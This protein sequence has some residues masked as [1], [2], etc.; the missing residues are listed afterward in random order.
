MLKVLTIIGARPQIIKAAAVSRA[1]RKNF[2]DRVKEI[3]VHTGQHYDENMSAVFFAELEIPQPDHN[4]QVGSDLQGKQ[5]A[6]MLNGIED[7]LLKEKPGAVI[8]YG[9][10]NSTLAGALVGSKLNVPVVHIEAGL[11]SFNKHMP[12]EINRIT[13]DHAATLLFAP[14]KTGFDNLVKEGL[15]PDTNP[16]YGVGN[17]KIFH[18]GDVMYDNSLHFAGIAEER[19]KVM[20]RL[21]LEKNKFVLATIHRDSNTDVAENLN[22]LFEALLDIHSQ[23]A[24]TIVLPLH[25]RTRRCLPEKL[26]KKILERIANTKGLIICEPLSFLDMI[27]LEKNCLL[28]MTDSGGVQKEAFYLGKPCVILREETEWIELVSSGAALLAGA[29]R[30][31]ITE[32][33][34]QLKDKKLPALPAF[35]GDGRAAEFICNEIVKFLS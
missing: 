19:S 20:E 7:V 15:R 12:E 21:E 22:S 33:Y 30:R 8:L 1:F 35:Y 28:V 25:P 23:Y 24:I 16:P 2:P 18:C 14:T 5:T 29:D 10:T 4:L 13:C 31:K 6:A 3:L 27:L 26:D 32:A 11:R 17:P 34:A 9:D